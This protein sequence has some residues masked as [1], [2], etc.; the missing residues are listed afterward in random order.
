MFLPNSPFA[1]IKLICHFCQTKLKS[2]FTTQIFY[3]I[4]MC[5]SAKLS[6]IAAVKYKLHLS[7]SGFHVSHFHVTTRRGHASFERLSNCE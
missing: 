7:T 4:G 6:H 2:L 3:E 1:Y 5:A